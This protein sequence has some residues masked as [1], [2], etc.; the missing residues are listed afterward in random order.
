VSAP[1][2]VGAGTGQAE[3]WTQIETQPV[4]P[5]TPPPQTGWKPI[6]GQSTPAP[7]IPQTPAGSQEG[8]VPVSS[9][10][11][12]SAASPPAASSG[13]TSNQAG[14]LSYVLG[15]VTGILFLVLDPYKQDRFVRFHAMQSTLFCAAYIVFSIAWRIFVSILIHI[16][17]WLALASAPIR[18]LITLGVI[19]LWLFLIY[20][21]YSSREFRI[22]FIGA[23]AAKQAR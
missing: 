2:T 21:A 11:A 4:P 10:P 17:P 22:P 6:A 15:F 8:Y 5:Q 1:A 19:L 3:G 12:T 23:I 16:S 18:L 9:P 7:A 20:Q 13:L 14:A